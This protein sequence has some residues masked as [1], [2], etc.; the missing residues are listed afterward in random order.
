MAGGVMIGGVVVV[1]MVGRVGGI[2]KGA[3]TPMA[4]TLAG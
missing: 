4:L 1:G 2:V 3:T